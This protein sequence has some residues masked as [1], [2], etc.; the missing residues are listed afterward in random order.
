MKLSVVMYHYVRDLKHSRYPNIKGLD[1]NLFKEQI[2]YLQKYYH[3]VT[4]EQVVDA[5]NGN[6]TLPPKAVLISFDDAYIDH[7]TN[8][9]PILYEKKIQGAFFTPVKAVT[10][11]VVLDVNKIHFVLAAA[12]NVKEVVEE[13]GKLLVKYKQQYRLQSFEYY[14]HKLA[15][16]E[17]YDSKEVVFVKRLLQVELVEQLRNIITDHLFKMFVSADEQAFSRELYLD[18]SQLKTMAD[19]GMHIGSHGYDH[20]WLASLTKD[21]Q[22]FEIRKSVEFIQNIYVNNSQWGGQNLTF[23][24]PYGDYNNDTLDILKKYHF[25]LGFTTKVDVANVINN[26]DSRFEL[27]RLDTNDF[28]KNKNAETNKWFEIG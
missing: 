27:P 15:T 6:E 1:L 14:F 25:Q 13:I 20:Y 11:H 10:E 4:V 19:C 8:V 9:F 22:E 3:F 23:C 12:H 5:F 28:P 21:K 18:K 17:R 7:Y 16:D 2:E 24:Y 26:G